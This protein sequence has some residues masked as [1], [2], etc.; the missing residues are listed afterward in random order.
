MSSVPRLFQSAQV[1][2]LSLSHR[3]VLAPLTRI[4]ASRA[5]V[6]R[7]FAADYYAQR[8]STAGTLLVSEGTIISPEAGG[9]P[10]LPEVTDAV[11]AKGSYIFLQLWALG[12]AAL[13]QALEAEGFHSSY[14]S[15]SD[16]R[17]STSSCA[18]RPVTVPEIKSY[19]KKYAIAAH[20][21]VHD[22]GFDG[23][24]LHGA[25]GY[26]VDQF[27]Q[28]VSNKRTDD[29]GGSVEKRCN[30]ALEIIEE[31]VKAV[32]ATKAAIRLSPWGDH[33]DMHMDNPVPTFSYLVKELLKRFPDLAYIHVV[34]PR[35]S[36]DG[37]R[38]MHREESNDFIRNIW[39]PRPLISTGGY[40]RELALKHAEQT[41][42]LIGFGRPF[43]SNPDLARR[44]RDNI[45]LA[46]W[47]RSTFYIPEDPFG[48]VDY[49][50]AD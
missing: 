21:A 34:E 48:Y 26:L 12:R 37:D 11:H 16:I 42:D 17:L 1:G 29:Y 14:I 22:A 43:I 25:N 39:A 41:D 31:V 2:E 32:G 7:E 38:D 28:D 9:Y 45:P 23:V 6:I 30:F 5:H 24:E 50:F 20:T 27:I 44:L 33:N 46:K 8:A 36:G 13:P 10:N 49:P 35:A 19:V 3:V 15:A 47:D 4:R 40:T 18:P